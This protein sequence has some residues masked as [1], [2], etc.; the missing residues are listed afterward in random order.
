MFTTSRY[1]TKP[2]DISAREGRFTR[3]AS[4]RW[5]FAKNLALKL[6]YDDSKDKSQYDYP[7]FGDSKLL[8]VSLQGV[9]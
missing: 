5:D 7:F 6:Q 3:S 4:V 1:M 9:F 2:N 8:S